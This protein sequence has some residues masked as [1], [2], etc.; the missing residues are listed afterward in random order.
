MSKLSK[1]TDGLLCAYE[2]AKLEISLLSFMLLEY[3]VS[4]DLQDIRHEVLSGTYGYTDAQFNE[5][6]NELE[7]Y[8]YIVI[9]HNFISFTSSTKKLFNTN[10]KRLSVVDKNLK[11]IGLKKL[12]VC[13]SAIFPTS[14]SVNPTMT[15]CALSNRL[16]DHLKKY[17]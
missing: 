8:G 15:L 5:S 11:I 9:N 7:Y 3:H 4:T 6:Y 10:H 17:L 13:S 16:G 14:G 1:A 12:Y 2:D